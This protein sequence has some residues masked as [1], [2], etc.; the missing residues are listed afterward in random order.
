MTS[1][2]DM[3]EKESNHGKFGIGGKGEKQAKF[4]VFQVEDYSSE[5]A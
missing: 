4:H 1:V 3:Y 5:I 2:L